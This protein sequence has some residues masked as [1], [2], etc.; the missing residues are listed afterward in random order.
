[1]GV[2]VFDGYAHCRT[3]YLFIL[4]FTMNTFSPPLVCFRILFISVIF[5]LLFGWFA[6]APVAQAAIPAMTCNGTFNF[7][8]STFASISLEIH[9]KGSGT[10]E[11][12][13]RPVGTTGWSNALPLWY[14]SRN[15]QHR[16]SLVN[17][18]S[19]T[20]YEV[21]AYIKE[22]NI[23]ACGTVRTMSE[24]FPVG[25]TTDLGTRSGEVRITEGGTASGYHLITGTS[26]T[27]GEN[28]IYVDAPYVIIRGLTLRN[29]ANSG[30]Q[31]GPRANY[32][33]IED[34]QITGFGKIRGDGG[35]NPTRRAWGNNV[36]S[37][38]SGIWSKAG[39]HLVIQ[40]NNIH[41][42][43]SDTNG[44]FVWRPSTHG[45][46]SNCPDQGPP[47]A[48]VRCHPEGPQGI[49]ILGS[50]VGQNIIR[51]NS[52]IGTKEHMFNDATGGFDNFRRDSGF[53][54]PNSD[55]YGNYI[56]GFQDESIEAEGSGKNVRIW[57]NLLVAI[58]DDGKEGSS[59][60]GI[61][62]SITHNGPRYVWKNVLEFKPGTVASQAVKAQTRM[63]ADAY[64]NLDPQKVS[65]SQT[66]YAR[67][68]DPFSTGLLGG[69]RVY[70]IHN[71]IM[72]T[73]GGYRSSES[74]L[75]NVYARNN[76][77]TARGVAFEAGGYNNSF[78][79]SLY[80][81]SSPTQPN[82]IKGTPTYV[83]GSYALAPKSLGVGKAQLIPGFSTGRD[84][85]AVGVGEKFSVGH[86]GT[87]INALIVDTSVS[88][89]DPTAPVIDLTPCGNFKSPTTPTGY[90]S[91]FNHFSGDQERI[92][93]AGCD[94][95]GFVP[96]TGSY[97]T[98]QNNFAVYQTGYYWTGSKW[99]S[100][101]FK[102]TSGLGQAS[103][104]N[105][106][107]ILGPGAAS[108]IPY[109]GDTTYFVAFTCHFGLDT[110]PKCGCSDATCASPKWQLQGVTRAK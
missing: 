91:A 40:R 13:Y 96:F 98:N 104:K 102:P 32:I 110:A 9:G 69:G 89:D 25:R 92:I 97:T 63:V 42:P 36:N 72:G 33:V 8:A 43:R 10:T 75:F 82:G 15:G 44:W 62:L 105:P 35:S 4:L 71:T 78:D 30:I 61:G 68:T 101:T 45:N 53:P 103:T 57:N 95:Q 27:G 88:T 20:N 46:Y 28:N 54:G 55:M 7:T 31:L 87:P 37:G 19:N 51:Y 77:M 29:A 23:L 11:V 18:S 48:K 3:N 2:P 47:P 107:W 38:N 16:G 6:A 86:T 94:D 41:T 65:P 56:T 74:S 34:N 108:R 52:I 109:Q 85:G 60:A 73:G 76:I 49:T 50:T 93:E 14:D 24:Q 59:V 22:R 66:R 79:Y 39:H 58:P 90:G 81:G 1:M 21:Q 99:Q 83:A 100:Y 12:R 106:G 70:F 64:K 80:T 5:S 26:V 84:I 17:L 67:A